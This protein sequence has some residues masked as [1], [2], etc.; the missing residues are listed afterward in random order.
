M[1][2]FKNKRENIKNPEISIQKNNHTDPHPKHQA[3][4]YIV[5]NTSD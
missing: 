4:K 1:N 3:L 5:E 2:E